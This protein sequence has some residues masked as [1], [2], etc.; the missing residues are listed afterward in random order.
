[1]E[2]RYRKK[3]RIDKETSSITVVLEDNYWCAININDEFKDRVMSANSIAKLN[4]LFSQ[5]HLYKNVGD[6]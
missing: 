5:I 3:V 4:D 2:D 1:M 6:K